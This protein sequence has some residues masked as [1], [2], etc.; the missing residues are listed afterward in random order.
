MSTEEAWRDRVRF[1]ERGLVPVVTQ[2]ARTR[3]VLMLAW[4][5]AEALAASEATG[6]ATY[7]SRSRSQLW[8]KGATSGHVQRLVQLTWD[9]DGD[10][11]LYLVEQTGPACH[12]GAASCFDVPGPGLVFAPGPGDERLA[13]IE[14]YGAGEES[15]R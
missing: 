10:T 2:E 14:L 4:A 9:C 12:T 8:V 13:P 5:N 1:D 3:R 6:Q 7:W 11:V 15:P